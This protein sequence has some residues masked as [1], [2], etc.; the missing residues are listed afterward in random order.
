MILF[1]SNMTMEG[2]KYWQDFANKLLNQV[3]VSRAKSIVFGGD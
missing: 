3:R 2:L 1:Y